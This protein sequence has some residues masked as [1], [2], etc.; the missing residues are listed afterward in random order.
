MEI[1]DAMTIEQ[2][3]LTESAPLAEVYNLHAADVPYEHPV[4]QEDFVES[5]TRPTR[6]LGDEMLFVAV[7][8]GQPKGFVHVGMVTD[9]ES[10]DKK[11]LIRFLAFPRNDRGMG[12]VLVDHAHAYL[13]SLG[14][15]ACQAFDYRFRYPCTWFGH[16]MSPWEHLY[17]LLGINGYHVEGN[18]GRVAVWPDYEVSEPVLSD[19]GLEVRVDDT[20][21]FPHLTSYGDLPT[22]V[23]RVLRNNEVVGGNETRPYYLPSW[24]QVPQNMCYTAGMGV[25]EAER[26]QGI[27]R[28]LMARSLFEMHRLGCR[29]AILDVDPSNFPALMLYVSM[30]YRTV[31][32]V[33]KMAKV[34]E[35]TA[36]TEG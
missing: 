9:E 28:Y 34:L 22:V 7:D 8:V 25:N 12:Q 31:Y 21:F 14:A 30:G 15:S 33:C 29:H 24:G 3:R 36:P 20:P 10:S 26:G 18:W 32:S 35:S 13:R 23:V 27:G 5:V 11:G 1:G 16:L 19:R 2:W 6:H 4:S 17:A